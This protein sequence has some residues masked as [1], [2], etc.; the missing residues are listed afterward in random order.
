VR[1][2]YTGRAELV[3]ALAEG[4]VQMAFEGL[5]TARTLEKAG[6]VK[7]VAT[8]AEIRRRTTPFNADR[9]DEAG[10]RGPRAR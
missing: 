8:P 7:I 3:Q 10:A 4:D 1:V 2:P 5:I 6:K 9:R